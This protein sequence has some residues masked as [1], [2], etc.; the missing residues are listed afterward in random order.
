[1]NIVK[2]NRENLIKGNYSEIDRRTETTE[3]KC[4]MESEL[5]DFLFK[6]FQINQDIQGKNGMK[7]TQ[8]IMN[9]SFKMEICLNFVV[10]KSSL[11]EIREQ[12]VSLYRDNIR[13]IKSFYDITAMNLVVLDEG[14]EYLSTDTNEYR[15][16]T[17]LSYLKGVA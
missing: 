6:L 7:S 13:R 4:N 10:R 5:G 12:V 14:E 2:I 9:F 1:M 17:N 16:I 3:T 15:N 11:D 8:Y